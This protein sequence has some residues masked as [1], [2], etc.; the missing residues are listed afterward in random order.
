M[1]R[2]S[3]QNTP[4]RGRWPFFL[5]IAT[6][7][8]LPTL[9]EID[10]ETSTVF[11][12]AGIQLDLPEGHE[13]LVAEQR[14]WKKCLIA[15]STL[16]AVDPVH[17]PIGFAA[18]GTRDGAPYLDQLSV[19]H[20]FLRMGIGTRLLAAAT[21]LARGSKSRHFWLTT[22]S[23]LPW[24]RPFYE[25]N[26]FAVVTATECGPEVLAEHEYERRWLPEPDQR[27]VMRRDLGTR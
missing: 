21:E 10:A 20:D 4:A 8:D 24:N 14:R 17:G 26:D 9:D 11:A 12:Q 16:L 18:L 15:G 25:L 19:R 1:P 22:Y 7:A 2:L 3:V 5:R 23:H 27:V 6:L 13:F